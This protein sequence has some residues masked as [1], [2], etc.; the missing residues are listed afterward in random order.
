MGVSK[1]NWPATVGIFT[2]IFAKESVIG[3]LNSLYD[4]FSPQKTAKENREFNFWKNI[5]EAFWE[6]P[7]GFSSSSENEED[8]TTGRKNTMKDFFGN[9]NRAFAYLLFI[10]LYEDL[11][12]FCQKLCDL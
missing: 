11:R 10:L 4:S 6:I 5:K 12:Y 1:K 9:K 8:E 2:G 3:T 7:A